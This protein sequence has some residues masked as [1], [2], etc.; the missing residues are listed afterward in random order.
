MLNRILDELRYMNA[1]FGYKWLSKDERPNENSAPLTRYAFK[2]VFSLSRE[3]RSRAIRSMLKH[4][5]LNRAI[6]YVMQSLRSTFRRFFRRN[7]RRNGFIELDVRKFNFQEEEYK[8]DA[9]RYTVK[10]LSS[11]LNF[12]LFT[13]GLPDWMNV[14]TIVTRIGKDLTHLVLKVALDS[15]E[16]RGRSLRN[17]SWADWLYQVSFSC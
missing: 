16:S 10:Y 2:N 6:R 7:L 8:S 14:A 13:E 9:S 1:D 5:M 17:G 12:P 15:P 11:K 4:H 3:R